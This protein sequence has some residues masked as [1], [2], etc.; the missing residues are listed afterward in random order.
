MTS[1][2]LWE[3]HN[4][5]MLSLVPPNNTQPMTMQNDWLSELPTLVAPYPEFRL[6]VLSLELIFF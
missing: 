5:M 3:L 1:E 2:M 6:S 4:T